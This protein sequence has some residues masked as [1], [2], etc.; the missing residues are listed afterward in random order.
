[1]AKAML[2]LIP[3]RVVVRM[4]DSWLLLRSSIEDVVAVFGAK[5]RFVVG[6][7]KP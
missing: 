3:C 6:A 5:R 4:S 7:E 1:M 2:S